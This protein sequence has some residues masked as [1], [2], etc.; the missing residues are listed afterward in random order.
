MAVL[1]G[2][3]YLQFEVHRFCG[4]MYLPLRP[5]ALTFL[6]IV[7]AAGLLVAAAQARARG[8][9]TVVFWAVVCLAIGK[10]VVVD[11][12]V[13]GLSPERLSFSLTKGYSWAVAAM[14]ADRDAV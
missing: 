8:L 1:A 4:V 6:W 2:F 10:L 13:W 7:L 12:R 9:L 11:L 3:V 5:P 14:R